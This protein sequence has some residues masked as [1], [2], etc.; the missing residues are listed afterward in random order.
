VANA[1][2]KSGGKK[3]VDEG[4]PGE[5]QSP[6]HPADAHVRRSMRVVC[7][8]QSPAA[9]TGLRKQSQKRQSPRFVSD[10]PASFRD[11]WDVKTTA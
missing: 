10:A 1:G 3:S 6:F 7:G 9:I 11:T 5:N 8:L 2:A 4:T